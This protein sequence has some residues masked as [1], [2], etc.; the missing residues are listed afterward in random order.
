VAESL[1]SVFADLVSGGSVAKDYFGEA[2][3]VSMNG[4][5]ALLL[6]PRRR[7]ATLEHWDGDDFAAT[8][9]GED[10]VTRFD[11]R[12]AEVDGQLTLTTSVVAE[13]QN[14]FVRYPQTGGTHDG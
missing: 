9:T 5:P 4:V 1:L 12:F 7:M 14:V 8:L 13:G 2:S 6:G 3:V 10:G 11:V